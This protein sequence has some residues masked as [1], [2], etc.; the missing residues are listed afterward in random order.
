MPEREKPTNL[1][2]RVTCPN[3]TTYMIV[4]IFQGGMVPV[5][6]LPKRPC[7]I[8]GKTGLKIDPAD[9]ER[10]ATKAWNDANSQEKRKGD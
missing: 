10:T 3:C 5:S 1:P 8:C 2:F 6:D 4:H 7:I 9:L